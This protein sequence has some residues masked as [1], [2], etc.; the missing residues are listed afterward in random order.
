MH[1]IHLTLPRFETIRSSEPFQG[2]NAPR[3][4][5]DNTDVQLNI[6]FYQFWTPWTKIIACPEL[7]KYSIGCVHPLSNYLDGLKVFQD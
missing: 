7:S 1:S 5:Q 6:A 4:L 2:Y 3:T